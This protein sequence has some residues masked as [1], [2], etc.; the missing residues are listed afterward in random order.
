MIHQKQIRREV[1]AAL[2]DVRIEDEHLKGTARI[3]LSEFGRP[4]R[5]R[6]VHDVDRAI[7]LGAFESLDVELL[8]ALVEEDQQE[9][10][11]QSEAA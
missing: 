8:E 6:V 2:I 7:A 4:D 9:P 10:I 11:R 5:E 3:I 1:T